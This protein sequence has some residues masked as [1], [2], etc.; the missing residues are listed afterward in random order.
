M[1]SVI[2]IL[3]CI[4]KLAGTILN[5][6]AIMF[7][8]WWV[9]QTNRRINDLENIQHTKAWLKAIEDGESPSDLAYMREKGFLK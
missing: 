8:A 5:S 1:D 3:S 9:R 2:A 6:V 7:L 4:G